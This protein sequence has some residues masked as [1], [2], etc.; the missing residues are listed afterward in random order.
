MPSTFYGDSFMSSVGKL[1]AIVV[2]LP[3][4]GLL[5][6]CGRQGQAPEP[7]GELHGKVT[8]KGQPVTGGKLIFLAKDGKESVLQILPDGTY[9]GNLPLG[10][11]Q[12]GIDTE[13]VKQGLEMQQGK[14]GTPPA[15]FMKPS[16][17]FIAK[18]KEKGGVG[19][20]PTKE[21]FAGSPQS[22]MKYVPVPEKYRNPKGSGL[23]VTV[24][25]GEQKKDFPLD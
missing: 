9:K 7:V 4:V 3:V 25:A 11:M 23:T 16:E 2:L 8:I 20:T 24:Q 14:F 6:G 21:D 19:V 1:C 10:E 5:E 17:E 15:G 22:G 12:V 13:I 18:A